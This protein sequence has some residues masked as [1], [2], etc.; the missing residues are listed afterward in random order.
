[1]TFN[2]PKRSSM[3]SHIESDLATRYIANESSHRL[4]VMAGGGS[5]W[6]DCLTWFFCRPCAMCQ[7]LGFRLRVQGTI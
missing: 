4:V 5:S 3:R 1:M 7:V 6:Q 2:D